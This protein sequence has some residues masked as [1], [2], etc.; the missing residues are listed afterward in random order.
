MC[1]HLQ[2][3][4]LA[5]KCIILLIITVHSV[6]HFI[7]EGYGCF[8]KTNS[9]CWGNAVCSFAIGMLYNPRYA[10]SNKR[11]NSAST[12]GIKNPCFD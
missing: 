11:T 6:E 4:G 8:E 5:V 1:K 12:D 7:K 10:I 9:Y 3:V 2:N